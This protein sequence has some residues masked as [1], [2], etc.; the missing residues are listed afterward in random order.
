M[1][2]VTVSHLPSTL[3]SPERWEVGRHQSKERRHCSGAFSGTLWFCGVLSHLPRWF[4]AVRRGTST[5]IMWNRRRHRSKCGQVLHADSGHRHSPGL[6]RGMKLGPLM[7]NPLSPSAEAVTL[8]CPA[9]LAERAILHCPLWSVAQGISLG[10]RALLHSQQNT[11]CSPWHTH[12]QKTRGKSALR[13][14]KIILVLSILL[15]LCLSHSVSLRRKTAPFPDTPVG[16]LLV[17]P[18][19]SHPPFSIS[20]LLP[21]PCVS[22]L[23]FP[24]YSNHQFPPHTGFTPSP[25]PFHLLR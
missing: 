10:L 22:P 3:C 1:V 15:S 16:P 23:F 18:F 4:T 7:P 24:P 6:Q 17:L 19:L 11:H 9:H 13:V 8:W 12:I 5:G 21:C 20:F 2:I 14:R 25:S